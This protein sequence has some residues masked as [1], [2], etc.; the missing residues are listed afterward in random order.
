MIAKTF[1]AALNGIEANLVDIEAYMSGGNPNLV[2]IGLP[3]TA[4]KES[5]DRVITAIKNSGFDYPF[6]KRF[7]VNLAPADLK[8]EGAAFDLPIALSILAILG[9][10]QP[11]KLKE[12]CAAGELALDGKIK[13]IRGS[14]P[15]ALSA[16]KNGINKIIVSAKNAQEASVINDVEIF[17]FE[18]LSQAAMFINGDLYQEP[19][20]SDASKDNSEYASKID[21]ADIKGQ[22]I[23]KRA[24]EVAAAGGHNLIMSGP[25]GSGKTMLAKRMPTILPQMTFE[26]S[27]ETTKIWSAAGQNF[28]GN[29]IRIRPFRSP[30]H[31]SSTVSLAGGGI[32]PK[33][34]E[35]SLAHNGILFLDEFSEFRRDALEI[36]RQ[37]LEDN[38]ITVSRIKNALTFPASF[39]L[40][41]AMNPCPCGNFGN[42]NKECVCSFIQIRRYLSKI[43]GPLLDRIDIHISMPAVNIEELTDWARNGEASK[44]IRDR[45]IAAREIQTERFKETKI[46]SNSQMN[47]QE[48][49][50]FCAID[51]KTSQMLKEIAVKLKLSARA[52]DRV[53]KVSRTIADL[54]KSENIKASHISEAAQ[55]RAA[56]IL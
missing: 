8:K 31:T 48:I 36:L 7:V 9:Y 37:P 30:H 55:Y 52:F 14:L 38:K 18:N 13:K 51:Q 2:I 1:S 27:I 54:D 44:T 22:F 20:V 45:V 33:P 3:D 21:F 43:S 35:V 5:K 15:I 17:P 41:A 47:A 28:S 56:E 49:K 12:F 39:M 42:P 26:E 40:I 29:L 32:Y 16:R 10:I 11:K 34:G 6:A 46:F 50:K 53:L 25:P 24:A 19:H 4:V 23:A